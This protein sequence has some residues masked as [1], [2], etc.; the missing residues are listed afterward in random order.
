M[1][2]RGRGS[3]S[4]LGD[5]RGRCGGGG[6]I[7]VGSGEVWSLHYVLLSLQ[8]E[9]EPDPVTAGGGGGPGSSLW[10]MGVYIAAQGVRRFCL[11]GPL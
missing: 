10:E 6:L 11:I 4:S 9:R 3:S 5:L 2:L 8:S 1:W 7:T